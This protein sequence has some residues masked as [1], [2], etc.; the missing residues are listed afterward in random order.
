MVVSE[1]DDLATFNRFVRDSHLLWIER[2]IPYSH[3]PTSFAFMHDIQEVTALN[4]PVLE[5]EL[6][7]AGAA[8]RH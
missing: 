3:Q 6:V 1:W 8:Q 7:P 2:S 5:R 4:T